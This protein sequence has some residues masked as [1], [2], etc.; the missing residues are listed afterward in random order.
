MIDMKLKKWTETESP[1]I[2]LVLVQGNAIAAAAQPAT[3]GS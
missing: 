3:T 1:F 2:V